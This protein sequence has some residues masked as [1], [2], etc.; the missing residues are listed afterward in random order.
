VVV[1]TGIRCQMSYSQ[2]FPCNVVA[3]ITGKNA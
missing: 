3:A 2:C 1:I